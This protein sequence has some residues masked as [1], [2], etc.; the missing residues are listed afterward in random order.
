MGRRCR[1]R[2]SGT[3]VAADGT[4]GDAAEFII[5]HG[6]EKLPSQYLKSLR[7]DGYVSLACILSA[8]IVDGLQIVG[9]VE[10]YEGNKPGKDH[11]IAMDASV[12]Q[13]TIEPVS[14]WLTQQYMQ[15]CDIRLGHPPSVTSLPPDDG[16]REV[17]GWHTDYPY[18]RGIGDRIGASGNLVL[19][20]QCNT[21]VSDF[22]VENGATMFKLGSHVEEAR[23]YTEWGVTN[24]TVMPGHRK[25]HGLPY[26]GEEATVIEAPAG[27]MVLYDARTWHCAGLNQTNRRRGA[28]IQA[29]VPGYIMPFMDT[30][31]AFKAFLESD[32]INDVNERQLLELEKADA[33]RDKRTAGVSMRSRLMPTLP[34]ACA[35]GDPLKSST[36]DA[37]YSGANDL[38]ENNRHAAKDNAHP[39]LSELAGGIAV[40]TGGASGIGY[41]LAETAIDHWL[42][43]CHCRHRP[44]INHNGGAESS[45][46]GEACWRRGIWCSG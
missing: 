26:S 12:L 3:D 30:S 6:P 8:E 40:I 38:P 14:L 11:P 25:K 10:E 29:F 43:S 28:M 39:D 42:T 33:V 15:H 44:R 32:V 35:Q 23:P 2:L 19:G 37:I 22:K 7:Q 31:A 18:L 9:C 27:S 17:T 21:C 46:T 24:N 5:G 20:M 13:A 41:S 45:T 1:L 16:K 4:T 36:I 34:G